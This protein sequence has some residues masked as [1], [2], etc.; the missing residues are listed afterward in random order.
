MTGLFLLLAASTWAGG[1]IFGDLRLG[2]KYLTETKLELKCGEEVVEG[3]TDEEGSF[4]IRVKTG[5]KCVLTVTHDNQTASLNVVVFD[6]P[7]RYRL[8]L[9]EKEGKYL[10]KRV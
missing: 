2:E 10:L 9:V 5:G 8:L 3:I 1:E 4:R 7:A 6:K